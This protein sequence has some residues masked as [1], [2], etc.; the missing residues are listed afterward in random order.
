MTGALS[1]DDAPVDSPRADYVLTAS[2]VVVRFGG[3]VALA[4]VD[5]AL[6]RGEI[7]GL[8]GPNG[9]GKTTLFDVLA[10]SRSA[11]AGRVEFDGVDITRRS[12][13][14]RARAGIRRTFQRQQLFGALTVRENVLAALE[15]TRGG[16]G[17]P[18][19][20]I[21]APSRRTLTEERMGKVDEVLT[22]CGLET[23]SN[24]VAADLPIGA[25]RLVELAR[26]LVA[27]PTVL[28]LD[29]PRSGLGA[30]DGVMLSNLLRSI[31]AERNLSI[32]LVEHDMGFVMALC[33]RIV[34]L[35]LGSVLAEGDPASIQANEAVRHAYLG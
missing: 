6:G 19:D 2:G 21:A 34:V 23:H 9:A 27:D 8:I 12:D 22:L 32:L 30:A 13:L 7:L 25:G 29:E 18:A 3:V 4:G 14:W 10:G 28:L 31:G 24:R 20:L 11:G 1:T 15:W 17:L 16:G 5:T 33:H 35:H 26:A